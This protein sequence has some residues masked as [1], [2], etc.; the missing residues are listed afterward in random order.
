MYLAERTCCAAQ[1][2]LLLAY[3]HPLGSLPCEDWDYRCAPSCLAQVLLSQELTLAASGCPHGV[4]SRTPWT[5]DMWHWLNN[6]SS[7]NLKASHL[8]R[9]GVKYLNHNFSNNTI[10][11]VFVLFPLG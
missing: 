4:L 6:G 10:L 7:H 3:T 9:A 1:A 11:E 5:G 2:D 8:M